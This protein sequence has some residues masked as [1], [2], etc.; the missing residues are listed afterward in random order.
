MR[1]LEGLNRC[2]GC[3]T[4]CTVIEIRT[5]LDTDRIPAFW[6]QL[7]MSCL[8]SAMN[9]FEDGIPESIEPSRRRTGPG[10][11]SLLLKRY[12]DYG[13]VLLTRAAVAA[14]C[15]HDIGTAE[16]LRDMN[17]S[18]IDSWRLCGVKTTALIRRAQSVS[19]CPSCATPLEDRP[20]RFDYQG[21]WLWPTR[22]PDEA[23]VCVE[24]TRRSGG[25]TVELKVEHQ[26]E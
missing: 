4:T 19:G 11:K 18:Q 22:V 20:S 1:R 8:L 7:C 10:K 2:D 16:A 3:R 9:C 12:D 24:G 14:L 26:T 21:A 15:H 17:L 6:I 5:D 13:G 25:V 23:A